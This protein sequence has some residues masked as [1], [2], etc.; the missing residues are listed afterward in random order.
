MTTKNWPASPV[1][2]IPMEKVT[3][4]SVMDYLRI[5]SKRGQITTKGESFVKANAPTCYLAV[6]TWLLIAEQ[7]A[8]RN[9]MQLLVLF[10][11][12]GISFTV[13][14][15]S[16]AAED[17]IQGN[18][19]PYGFES[20]CS[21][22]KTKKDQLQFL[23]YLK[24]LTLVQCDLLEERTVKSFLDA[25]QHCRGDVIPWGC[26]PVGTRPT[27][28]YS[29]RFVTSSL[30]S[31][32]EQIIREVRAIIT[33]MCHEY[34][35]GE[36][37]FS[38]GATREGTGKFIAAKLMERAF[39]SPNL[40]ETLYYPLLLRPGHT[41]VETKDHACKAVT[42]PKS[43][44]AYRFIAMEG[45]SRQFDAQGVREGLVNSV[46]RTGYDI[47]VDVT[48]QE[49][50]R[51]LC[52]QGSYG[53]EY[54]TVDLTSASD[55]VSREFVR[56]V[57]PDD[58]IADM[59]E[60]IPDYVYLS[61]SDRRKLW[62]YSTAGNATTFIVESIVFTAIALVSTNWCKPY[63]K[64]LKKPHV[65]GDDCIVDTRV[66]DFFCDTLELL[67]FKVS[68][69]KSFNGQEV[70]YRESCGVEYEAGLD[71][72]SVYFPRKNLGQLTK[73]SVNSL[74]S[75]CQMQHRVYDFVSARMFLTMVVRSRIAKMTSHR[76]GTD[77]T[78]L[79]EDY[80]LCDE[81]SAP[82]KGSNAKDRGITR[83]FHLAPV[84]TYVNKE[85]DFFDECN[86]EMWQYVHF[87]KHGADYFNDDIN[88]EFYQRAGI[89]Q[90]SKAIDYYQTPGQK[91]S[92]V[93]D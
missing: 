89:S 43:Y 52:K 23:R 7:I 27:Y 20:V 22:I 82:C 37:S 91:W 60:V 92:L 39:F 66:F 16:S 84:P 13:A 17:V 40:E 74:A 36:K 5:D 55:L 75:V 59:L 1:G 69:S 68:H 57:F 3:M 86:V 19:L 32:R 53:G 71:I 42:V 29:S 49:S 80:P 88:H 56:L 26:S 15:A 14:A 77:C 83:E 46:K 8:P 10:Q 93:I 4:D 72:S 61:P 2:N 38:S 35:M 44:K 73:A 24:R 85:V 65:F 45:A 47:Y 67:G 41:T 63:F 12:Y 51:E 81:R 25:N 62:M 90:R 30:Y 28:R 34:K 79:W 87:L 70:L 9:W 54:A 6:N 11:K 18:K 64:G 58:V 33:D 76:P 78:D 48:D 31:Y 21:E 50:N